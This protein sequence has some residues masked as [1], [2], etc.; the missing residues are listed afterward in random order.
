VLVLVVPMRCPVWAIA[1]HHSHRQNY[2]QSTRVSTT[3]RKSR[4]S[5]T[6]RSVTS[7]RLSQTA[8]ISRH[9]TSR[10]THEVVQYHGNK[11]EVVYTSSRHYGRHHHM[12]K[13]EIARQ[14]KVRYAYPVTMFMMT[15]PEFDRSPLSNELAAA[16]KAAFDQGIAS[17]LPASSLVRAGIFNYHPLKGGIFIRRETVKYIIMH[18]TETGRPVAA[19]LVIAG[20]NSLGRRHAGAQFVVDRDGAIYQALD[21]ELA[22]VH[23]NVFKTLP[24][25]NNDNSIGI[26]M[27]HAGA[28]EYTKPQLDSVS[29]LVVY[30]Q[31]RYHVLDEDIITHKYA[32]QGDHTDPVNFAWDK[33]IAE[34]N[35]LK[36][37]AIALRASEV[38]AEPDRWQSPSPPVPEAYLQ[39][40]QV[41]KEQRSVPL[42]ASFE[43]LDV[44][45]NA[46]KETRSEKSAL[47]PLSSR[48]EISNNHHADLSLPL[49]GP[50]EIDPNLAPVLNVIPEDE[51][52]NQ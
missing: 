51:L 11:R 40:H 19:P 52:S 38:N 42:G 5:R 7:A 13:R 3:S 21:P 32:Q 15:A 17:R 35:Q 46:D 24:G 10:R 2:Q 49:R 18:S 30:L 47:A 8:A 50:I 34:K 39:V 9:R 33:F 25:I 23:V 14:P 41:V 28:Q 22:S 43:L 48:K 27:S 36:E 37:T 1:S 31:Q 4:S 12:T 29:K 45:R 44:A 6:A 20:W 16:Y 26:E